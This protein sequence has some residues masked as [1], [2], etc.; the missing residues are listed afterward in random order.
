MSFSLRIPPDDQPNFVS[1]GERDSVQVSVDGP[2]SPS[3]DPLEFK[4]VTGEKGHNSFF[5][6]VVA[7]IF[8]SAYKFFNYVSHYFTSCFSRG[9]FQ[10]VT[11]TKPVP[12]SNSIVSGSHDGVVERVAAAVIQERREHQNIVHEYDQFYAQ[13]SE[14]YERQNNLLQNY[15]EYLQAA[16]NHLRSKL[17]DHQ[18]NKS[19]P[20]KPLEKEI[21]GSHLVHLINEINENLEALKIIPELVPLTMRAHDLLFN[22]KQENGKTIQ[23]SAQ[24]LAT[25]IE[26]QL[27]YFKMHHISNKS[28]K[29][30]AEKLIDE[31]FD[32]MVRF[33]P[34]VNHVTTTEFSGR[35]IAPERIPKTEELSTSKVKADHARL[36]LLSYMSI[37]R[38]KIEEEVVLLDQEIERRDRLIKE[39][40]VADTRKHAEAY[41]KSV[42]RSKI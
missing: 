37:L 28:L 6:S 25:M 39:Q 4:D 1:L 22:N 38:N 41:R 34:K 14:F 11:Q 17:R 36:S 2:S 29:Q 35:R 16:L 15:L 23:F 33:D 13:Y 8:K 7:R 30:E 5:Y 9:S 19:L 20:S 40:V 10:D 3:I 27:A 32:L 26:G 18:L 42:L 12:E 24:S 21:K 31:E